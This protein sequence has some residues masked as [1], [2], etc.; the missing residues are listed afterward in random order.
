[1]KSAI[2]PALPQRMAREDERGAR[3]KVA[4]KATTKAATKV[5][6][7]AVMKRRRRALSGNW[8]TATCLER[9]GRPD[10]RP[11][12]VP[13]GAVVLPHLNHCKNCGSIPITVKTFSAWF[14][15]KKSL[16]IYARALLICGN[17]YVFHPINFYVQYMKKN[18]LYIGGRGGFN[19]SSLVEE[20]L[21]ENGL[22]IGSIPI[23]VKT[24]SAWFHPTTKKVELFMQEHYLPAVTIMYSIQSIFMYNTWKRTDYTLGE[25]GGDLIQVA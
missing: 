13:W 5:A 25:G 4:T 15:P 2:S 1:M 6:S 24:F 18:R 8:S 11:W 20:H 22:V 16:I 10:L 9:R 19:S 17:R 12:G 7:T 23:A 14:H 3:R 21:G